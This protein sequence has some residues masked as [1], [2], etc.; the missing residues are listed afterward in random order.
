MME[1]LDLTVMNTPVWMW[2][3]FLGC[4]MLLLAFDLGILHRT[5][6]EI[7]VKQSL[8]LSLFYICIGLIFGIF[9]WL[10]LGQQA[11]E[12]YYTGFIIEKSLSM[13][14]IFVI[15]LVFSYFAIPRQY[16]YRVLF[17]G[18]IG[19][20]ILRALLIG[21]GAELVHRFEWTLYL[22]AAFLV[23]T[24]IK[25]LFGTDEEHD[26]SSNPVIRFVKKY[27]RVTNDLHGNKFFVRQIDANTGKRSSFATPLFM[28]LVVV[29]FVD[30][31]FAI[32]SVPAIFAVTTDEY[33]IYTS[34]IFAILG[35]RALY[36][37]LSAMLHRFEYLKYSLSAVLI[38]IG[39]KVIVPGLFGFEKVPSSISLSVTI[40]LLAVGVIYS[41]H[42]TKKDAV[43]K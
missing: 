35:L 24:G 28:A 21:V 20:L 7:T 32:D 14:N 25:M 26:I 11:A 19:V 4:V 33:I 29:E 42:R 5:D 23:F 6:K 16:Q 36:F 9:V 15:S 34:N 17:W 39:G 41:L 40:G 27:M 18:I 8:R 1:F 30:L 22:F 38:F 12:E 3:A 10:Q 13:D 43:V 37:A 31:I 2:G